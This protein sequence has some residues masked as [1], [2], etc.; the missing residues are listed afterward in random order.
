MEDTILTIEEVS[1]YIKISERTIYD[2][3]QKGDI[4]AGKLGNV[5]RFSKTDIDQWVNDKLKSNKPKDIGLSNLNQL[6]APER[7]LITNFSTKR[8]I[9]TSLINNIS[10]AP[11]IKDRKKL[12]KAIWDRESLMSTGIGLGIGI[13]HIRINSIQDIVVSV[14]VNK[15][16]IIDYQSLDSK[17]VR[18]VFM[19]AAAQNQHAE[20]LKLLASISTLL[21]DESFR[22]KLLQEDDSMGIYN[23]LTKG[24]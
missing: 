16:D 18:I 2:W 19:V 13:P 17:A 10:E 6:L 4:P 21:K 5:W 7:V 15:T 9:L 24:E 11:Q 20:Y 12:E 14:A 1:K 22:I 23:L 3:A 8:D